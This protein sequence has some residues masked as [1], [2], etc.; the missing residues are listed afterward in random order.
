MLSETQNEIE[1]SKAKLLDAMAGSSDITFIRI[2]GNVGDQLIYA[3]AR[4]LLSGLQYKETSILNLS[5]AVGDLALI[6]GGGAWCGPYQDMPKHL[7]RVEERFRRVIVLPSSFDISVSSVRE[8]LEKTRALVFARERVSYEQIRKLC[9]SDLAH[10]CAFFFDYSPYLRAGRG[11]LHA[12]RTDAEALPRKLPADNNDISVK[13][14]TLD[15][16]LWTISRHE[17]R[18]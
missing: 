18:G 6:A 10:D 8:A 7:P 16:W 14:E 13:C 2:Y 12:Y 5:G 3:G 15:E 4:R 9:K 11:A 1:K 17:V